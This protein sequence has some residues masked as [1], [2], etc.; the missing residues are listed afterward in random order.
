MK[1]T[2]RM[3]GDRGWGADVAHVQCAAGLTNKKTRG[4]NWTVRT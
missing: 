4:L 1:R 2:R 3:T